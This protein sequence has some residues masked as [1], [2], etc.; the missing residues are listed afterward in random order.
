MAE[1]QGTRRWPTSARTPVV[2]RVS[3]TLWTV[4]LLAAAFYLWTAGSSL[5]LALH[6]ARANPYNE[7]ANAFVHFRLSVGR[8]PA[9]LLKLA[10][11]YSPA[12]NAGFRHG[13]EDFSLYHG[14]LFLTWGPA[15][16]IVLLVPA[17]VLGLEPT[18]SLTASLF[19]IV[20][21]GFALTTLRV[22]LRQ[23]GEAPIW[24]VVLAALSVTLC[25]GVPFMLRRPEIYEEA[26]SG[27]YCFAMASVWLAIRALAERRTSLPQLALMSLCVGLAT[28]SR[29]D[30]VVTG[31]MLVPVYLALRTL[32][33]RRGLLM[34][35][36]LPLGLCLIL[37]LAYNQAR[38][39]NPLESG[40]SYQLAGFNQH[41]AHFDDLSYVP[42]GLWLYSLAPPRASALFPFIYLTPP[43]LSYPGSL[44]A[45]YHPPERTG[46]LLPMAPI[47]IMLVALPWISRRRSTSLARLAQPLLLLAGA[48]MACL[49]FLSYVFFTTTERYEVDFTTM[50]LLGAVATWLAVG[51]DADGW[52]RRL[53]QIGGG[54]LIVW[55]CVAGLAV[56][57]SGYAN[58]LALNHPATWKTLQDIG[59]P[60]SRAIAILEGHPVLVEVSSPQLP[61]LDVGE[62]AEV[63]VVSPDARAAALLATWA[64]AVA[65]GDAVERAAY[66]SRVLVRGPGHASATYAI[67]AG[68]KTTRVPV[69]LSPGLNRIALIP[70]ATAT[71]RANTPTNA[72]QLLYVESVSV[73]SGGG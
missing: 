54:V 36:T 38:F 33:P 69:Q 5:P 37:L 51:H 45:L 14:K 3:V 27:G 25:S 28:A 35:L 4:F 8:A 6:G 48:G 53:V 57:F 22:V 58:L 61:L 73:T 41:T 34:A 1:L 44:P 11:P 50:F 29:P 30:L 9:G 62:Q 49:L 63:I 39:G 66:A 15:P 68:G 60:L 31:V 13:I 40:A 12:Q 16:V 71:K 72:Q 43:P 2:D 56:S 67:P 19:A 7:L 26:I 64:P 55:G 23:I 46:G 20:G 42:P 21:L 59:S 10:E 24:M 18:A 70:L 47:L 32:R 65:R 17:Y 52:R